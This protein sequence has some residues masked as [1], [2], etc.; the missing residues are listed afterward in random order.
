MSTPDRRFPLPH[1][2]S[3]IY[4][5]P[6]D[7]KNEQ[8]LQRYGLHAYRDCDL[9]NHDLHSNFALIVAESEMVSE[10]QLS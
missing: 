3:G 7:Y 6:F 10:G 5:A 1:R 9:R 2:R 4:W 8:I